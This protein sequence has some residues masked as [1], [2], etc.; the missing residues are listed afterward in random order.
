M[1]QTKNELKK[2]KKFDHLVL[3]KIMISINSNKE[4]AVHDYSDL[5]ENYFA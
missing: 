2:K 3:V 5:F 4:K 1:F